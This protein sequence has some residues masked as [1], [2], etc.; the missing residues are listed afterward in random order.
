M[1]QR[2][3]LPASQNQ[4][5]ASWGRREGIV[6][7]PPPSLTPTSLPSGAME[8]GAEAEGQPLSEDEG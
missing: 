2:M 3:T 1:S 6:M 8:G 4:G 7:A 5:K